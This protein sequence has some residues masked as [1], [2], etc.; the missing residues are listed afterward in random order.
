M[1]DMHPNMT[2]RSGGSPGNAV[3]SSDMWNVVPETTD[4]EGL[5]LPAHHIVRYT[6]TIGELFGAEE[7]R[8]ATCDRGSDLCR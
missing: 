5:R 4:D 3:Q 2:T 8:P 7:F 1:L 6:G